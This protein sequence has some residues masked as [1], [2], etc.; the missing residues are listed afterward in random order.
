VKISYTL[1]ELNSVADTI[2]SAFPYRNIFCFEG[3]LGA[4][5]TTLIET[6]CRQLGSNDELSSPTF[7]IINEYSA[8]DKL[9]FHMDWYRL[10]S[11]DE[12]LNIGIEDNLFSGNYCF[13]EWY[14]HAEA[15][16]PR[17]YI[18]ISIQ[19]VDENSRELI[20]SQID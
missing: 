7:S 9:I 19:S 17:P 5:K 20:V 3:E 13:I 6:I 18:L 4:G 2:L 1:E 8:L 10:Q 15:I 16:I 12:A 14:Q 11:I